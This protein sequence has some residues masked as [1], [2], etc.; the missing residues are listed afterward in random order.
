MKQFFLLTVFSVLLVAAA[1]NPV[2]KEEARK[3]A[4]DF[5]STQTS[6]K[7]SGNEVSDA[8]TAVY[9]GDTTFYVFHFPG[10]VLSSYPQMTTQ[11]PYLVIP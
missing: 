3:L 2:Y 4:A 6:V 11:I 5:Y 10:V 7:V 1:A 8:Y 9:L